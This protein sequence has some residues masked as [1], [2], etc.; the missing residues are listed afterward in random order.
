MKAVKKIRKPKRLFREELRA[1]RRKGLILSFCAVA[2][3]FFVFIASNYSYNRSASKYYRQQAYDTMTESSTLLASS[4]SS[5]MRSWYV[6]LNLAEQIVSMYAK[7]PKNYQEADLLLSKLQ[8]TRFMDFSQVGLITEDGVLL[9]SSSEYYNTASADFTQS[10]LKNG[11]K[12][13]TYAGFLDIEALQDKLIFAI[14]YTEPDTHKIGGQKIVGIAA[15]ISTKQL[16]EMIETDFFGKN[17]AYVVISDVNGNVIVDSEAEKQF[18]S[19]LFD[20]FALFASDDVIETLHKDFIEGNTNTL[21]LMGTTRQF[22]TYYTPIWPDK[23]ANADDSSSD[24]CIEHWRLMIMTRT[25]IVTQNLSSLFKDS[26]FLLYTI[27]GILLFV[28]LILIFVSIRKGNRQNTLF[29]TDALTGLLNDKRLLLDGNLLLQRSKNGREKN[30]AVASYNVRQ[31]KLINHQI[32][33]KKADMILQEIGNVIQDFLL[34]D[35]L[36]ARSFADRFTVFL[37]LDTVDGKARLRYLE[38][39]LL[40]IPCTDTVQLDFT[41]GIYEL[42]REDRDISIAI[43]H[44]RFAQS[45]T[46]ER[47]GQNTNIVIY[48]QEMFDKQAEER[49][50]ERRAKQALIN[51]DFVV[52]YQ[53]KRDIQKKQWC[54]CEA[55]IRWIDPEY[56]FLSPG[57]FIPLFERNGFVV[58]LDKYVFET[59]CADLRAAIDAGETVLPV[60]INVSKCHLRDASFIDEYEEIIERYRIPHNLLEFEIT[61]GLVVENAHVLRQ[62]IT[63]LHALGCLCSLDDFGSGYSSFNMVKEFDFDT[64]KL[65]RQFFYG[66]K[67]FDSDSRLI[68]ASLIE[69]SHKLGKNVISEGVELEDQVAFLH[70]KKCDAIQGFYFSKPVPLAECKRM[71]QN[72]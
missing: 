65:D 18:G 60:S 41:I 47:L 14:P 35:E 5:H 12:H 26:R 50:L 25:D 38:K 72:G 42:K 28:L 30:Y 1:N 32:G 33:H 8:D 43:D 40:A 3:I 23:T 11:D 4:I 34:P 52:Y 57:T 54:G 31:F 22:M 44:A 15:C 49:R 69:L 70:A 56:G 9:F 27:L 2:A 66:T 24:Y 53:L 71:I 19:N 36:A 48:S 45:K 51:H 13:D 64:I 21:N 46:R 37:R 67:G 58:K 16:S 61:E 20:T 63:K 6:E 59:V 17:Y 62:L 68:V 7:N 55:L 39:K 10:I 29:Y